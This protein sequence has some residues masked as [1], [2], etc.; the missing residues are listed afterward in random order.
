MLFHI[1]HLTSVNVRH[2]SGYL[3]NYTVAGLTHWLPWHAP[4]PISKRYPTN[5]PVIGNSL[6]IWSQFRVHFGNKKPLLLSSIVAN[7][8]FPPS[9]IDPAFKLWKSRG[10]L[11]VK[12]FFKDGHF[13]SFDYVK[14][15]FGLPNTPFCRYLQ[16]GNDIKICFSPSLRDI[17]KGWIH[18]CVERDPRTKG[19]VSFVYDLI[20][21]TS[22]PS[23]RHIKTKWEEDLNLQIP[24]GTWHLAINR[25]NTSFICIRQTV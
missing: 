12:D 5:N 10:L 19:F 9:L 8:Y 2:Q 23:L 18:D 17:E 13:I 14:V 3:W 25:V 24:D 15:R 11:C 22:A 16:I 7:P 6:W 4:L 21:S 20:Q 1:G